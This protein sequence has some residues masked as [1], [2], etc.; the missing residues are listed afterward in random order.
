MSYKIPKFL[1]W[2]TVSGTTQAMA[3]DNGYVVGNA[4]LT[5]LTLPTVAAVGDVVA[6]AGLGAAGW[7]VAQNASQLIHVGASVSTTGIGGYIASTTQ[8]D[9]VMLTCIVANTTWSTVTPPQGNITVA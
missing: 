2:S 6:V 4:G 1:T 8:Y 5:T 7:I 9:N 3:I